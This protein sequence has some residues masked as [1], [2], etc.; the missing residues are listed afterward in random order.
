[1]KKV[2]SKTLDTQHH[3]MLASFEQET[4]RIREKEREL[5]AI[6]NELKHLGE[7]D[8]MENDKIIERYL[9]LNNI[10][11]KVDRELKEA[12]IRADE[13]NYFVD[14][15][16]IVFKY[17]DII[18]KGSNGDAD[19]VLV[20]KNSILKYFANDPK[21][22]EQEAGSA[23]MIA[24]GGASEEDRASLLDRY[25][26]QIDPNYVK[27]VKQYCETCPNCDSIHRTVFVNDGLS[28]CNDCFTIE[29]I[30][31]DHEKPSYKDPPKEISYFCY[32]RINHLSESEL[33]ITVVIQIL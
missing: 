4:Q 22:D 9:H 16:D 17:Y 29:T 14:T 32:K 2:A 18:E 13:L 3:R 5:N 20:G 12:K 11:K 28:Y 26:E 6:T 25:M 30:I 27:N 15:A 8:K 21:E 10:R 24:G 33:I 23:T 7:I 31:I 1:M 19:N